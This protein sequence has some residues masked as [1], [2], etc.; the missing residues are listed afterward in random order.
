M[1]D[2]FIPLAQ[3]TGLI[4]PLTLYV[5][6]EALQQCRALAATRGSRLSIAVNL[7]T[8]NLLDLEFPEQVAGLLEH[9]G[10]DP[11]ATGVRDHRVDDARRPGAD[12]VDPRASSRRWAS[13]S[14]STTSAPGY[15]SLAYLKRLPVDEIKIDRSFVMHMSDDEDDATIVRST[16]DLG[17]QPRPPGRRRGRRDRGG[18]EHPQRARLHD[19]PGLLPQP[20]GAPGRAAHVAAGPHA[21]GRGDFRPAGGAS[22]KHRGSRARSLIGGGWCGRRSG[23]TPPSLPSRRSDAGCRPASGRSAPA[24]RRHRAARAGSSVEMWR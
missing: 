12:E 22:S 3:Q 7:S 8:R 19:R 10:V 14:R 20:S 24:S 21:G 17:Q 2:D 11:D 5:V 9:W 15:S 18:L 23:P 1:P 6:G 4:K 16:I 13:G